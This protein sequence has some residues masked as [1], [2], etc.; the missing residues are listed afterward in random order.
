MEPLAYSH[1]LVVLW[2]AGGGSWECGP[3]NIH[4]WDFCC[5][6]VL[7]CKNDLMLR[8]AGTIPAKMMNSASEHFLKQNF[9]QYWFTYRTL[10]GTRNMCSP[11]SY[12]WDT[13]HT[14]HMWRQRKRRRN[15]DLVHYCLCGEHWGLHRYPTVSIHGHSEQHSS[16]K[17]MCHH[18]RIKEKKKRK[19]NVFWRV[20]S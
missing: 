15:H 5:F 20:S 6:C 17:R 13:V 14:C 18:L 12:S 2:G 3:S 9:H 8:K 7:L 16:D 19:W 10:H 1:T 4:G 11:H